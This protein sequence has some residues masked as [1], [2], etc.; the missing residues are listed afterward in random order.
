M[1]GNVNVEKNGGKLGDNTLR[2]M[3]EKLG[4]VT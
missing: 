1:T 2:K 3:E 4:D